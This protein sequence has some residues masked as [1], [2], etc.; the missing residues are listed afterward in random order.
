MVKLELNLCQYISYWWLISFFRCFHPQ[1]NI[2]LFVFDSFLSWPVCKGAG[3]N[4][5]SLWQ[6][7]FSLPTKD[8]MCS[9]G[10]NSLKKCSGKSLPHKQ[11]SLLE[12]AD[13]LFLCKWKVRRGKEIIICENT[14]Q[15]NLPHC[16]RELKVSSEAFRGWNWSSGS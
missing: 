7:N 12:T 4:Y 13:H 5:F 1:R 15:K 8:K 10:R 11:A 3:N 9:K 2:Q 14:D 6:S 16:Y